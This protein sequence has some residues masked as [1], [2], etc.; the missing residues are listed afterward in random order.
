MCFV[1]FFVARFGEWVS[2][3]PK[4]TDHYY[5]WLSWMAVNSTWKWRTPKWSGWCLWKWSQRVRRKNKMDLPCQPVLIS[6]GRLLPWPLPN[7]HIATDG[8]PN[9]LVLFL[10]KKKRTETQSRCF[11]AWSLVVVPL[12]SLD[13]GLWT[14]FLQSID[15]L[16]TFTFTCPI[17]NVNIRLDAL[18]KCSRLHR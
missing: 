8:S 3:G 14:V 5:A 9:A 15:T 16:N 17:T 7:E 4:K 10:E 1:V 6:M 18:I 2:E 11:M 13:Q 12:R